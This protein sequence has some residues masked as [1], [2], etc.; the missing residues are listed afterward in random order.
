MH[1]QEISPTAPGSSD[2]E[3]PVDPGVT[4]H[5]IIPLYMRER[6][7]TERQ[8]QAEQNDAAADAREMISEGGPV[9]TEEE[10]ETI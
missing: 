10:G 7:A 5:T 6:A 8:R 1:N 9:D 4:H 3:R 2:D